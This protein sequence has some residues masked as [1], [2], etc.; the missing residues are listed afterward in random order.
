MARYHADGMLDRVSEFIARHGMLE[1]GQR[2]G[3]AFRE[4]P[5]L[6][7]VGLAAVMYLVFVRDDGL[8][9][10]V[11]STGGKTRKHDKVETF[12]EEIHTKRESVLGKP[13]F[14]APVAAS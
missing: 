6:F 2:V 14:P 12:T 5:I 11:T 8:W 1:A 3:V 4:K 7:L 10:T 9:N 13:T